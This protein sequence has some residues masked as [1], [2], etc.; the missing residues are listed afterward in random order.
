MRYAFSMVLSVI[1]HVIDFANPVSAFFVEQLFMV[2]Y[3]EVHE[4][5]GGV[6]KREKLQR[7]FYEAEILEDDVERFFPSDHLQGNKVLYI[8]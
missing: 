7:G 6:G 8:L 5:F 3:I 1:V 2:A 4:L